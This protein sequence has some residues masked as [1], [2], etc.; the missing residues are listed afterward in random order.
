M[1]TINKK[2]LVA[3]TIF[4]LTVFAFV[5][6]CTATT[7]TQVGGMIITDTEWTRV[8]GPYSLTSPVVVGYGATLHIEDGA[9]VNLNGYNLQVN[10]ILKARGINGDKITFTSSNGGAIVFSGSSTSYD[11][12]GQTG[13][14]IENAQLNGVYVY[15][16]SGA[17]KIC[18]C[19]MVAPNVDS[20]K[21]AFEIDS[22]GAPV[23]V[24]N[25][26]NGSIECLNG[27]HPTIMGNLIRG[28]IRSQGFDLSQPII[29]NN[30]IIG[31]ISYPGYSSGINACGSNFYIANNTISGCQSAI[32]LNEG[33]NTIEYNLIFNN[34]CGIAISQNEYATANI[35]HNTIYNNTQGIIVGYETNI[36]LIS[37]IYNNLVG[38]SGY[39]FRG[40]NGTYNWWGTTNQTAINSLLS[41]SSAYL[42][43]LTSPD[44][45]APAIPNSHQITVPTDSPAPTASPSSTAYTAV[46]QDQT[47]QPTTTPNTGTEKPT[48]T[49]YQTSEAIPEFTVLIAAGFIALSLCTATAVY[50]RR[51]RGQL[52][53]PSIV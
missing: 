12:A 20:V 35:R 28:G 31:G 29:I 38:N 1:Q 21:M 19:T 32:M 43:I 7:G 17:P 5:P 37:I 11:E 41:N 24:G 25:T 45:T 2:A 52:K 51:L 33:T 36:Q 39:D 10:G 30:T 44:A 14:I 27:A 26:I 47:A 16:S 46:N 48:A 42:P 8:M 3:L 22:A 13:C 4:L 49:P 15:V 40:A 53:K 18:G 34:T 23:I 50:Y 6:F 9:V